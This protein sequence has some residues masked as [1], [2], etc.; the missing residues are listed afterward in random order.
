MGAGA[1]GVVRTCEYS[2]GGLRLPKNFISGVLPCWAARR[3]REER[4][5]LPGLV[6]ESR[7][8]EMVPE[9]EMGQVAGFGL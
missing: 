5:L 9:L 4:I 8:N 2:L 7:W 6:V 1:R 3:T